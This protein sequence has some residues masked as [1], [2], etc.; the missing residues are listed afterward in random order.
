MKF[1]ITTSIAYTNAPPHIGFALE[2]IQA[3]VLAR[4]HRLL[5]D[6]VYFLTGTDEN[7]IKNQKSALKLS[8]APQRFV[9]QNTAQV[10]KL[11]KIL[12]ISNNDF[13]RTTDKTRHWPA[14]RKIWQRLE[15]NGDIYKKE[16][17]GLYCSGCEAF[18]TKKDLDSQG[19]CRLHKKKPEKIR[20]ENYFFRLSKYGEYIE[21]I[22]KTGELKIIPEIRKRELLSFIKKGIQDVSFSRPASSLSW[23]IPVPNDPSQTIY[24][25][26]DALTNYISALGYADDSIKF[27]K[28]WPADIHLIGKDITRFHA[29]IWPAML[30]SA[31]LPLPKEILVHGFISVN[32]QKMSKS[33]GN[34][35][36][37]FA[38]SEKYPADALRYYLLS[39]IPSQGDGNF[40]WETFAARY[41]AD[42]VSGLGNLVAR[43]LKMAEKYCQSQVPS[44]K[45]K[46]ESH[47]LFQEPSIYNWQKAQK[48]ISQ[49]IADYQFHK[50]VASL[51]QFVA[52]MNRYIDKTQPWKMAKESLREKL[53]WTIYG[54]LD[55]L[56]YSEQ[57]L[58]LF[59]PETS[60]KIKQ[61]FNQQTSVPT[62]G[63]L[64]KTP[65]LEPGVPLTSL[66]I[67]FPRL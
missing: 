56:Y 45:K 50:A 2:L 21:N 54:L 9:N 3:D 49:Y 22:I 1:Y 16:Y 66:P 15:K 31:K 26:A 44:I 43:T 42:L 53:D 5:G 28:Y 18:V 65:H 19:R 27:Q 59:L 37:P 60:T 10:E 55:A 46:P 35:V 4:Y 52:E 47:S 7:G 64:I 34:I 57:W 12:S 25:W 62:V 33:L 63:P 24:V 58:A 36:S 17:E 20:E 51:W 13:I 41:K 30:L 11:T 14:V 67:L 38:V 40:S 39:E 48:N 6:D 32:G 8:I 23:G 61:I 29:L